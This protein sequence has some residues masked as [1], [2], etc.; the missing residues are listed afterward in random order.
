MDPVQDRENLIDAEKGNMK[1]D[2]K[3]SGVLW[4]DTWKFKQ[5]N[6]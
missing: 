4:K 1:F 2:E 5:N 6:L 3:I